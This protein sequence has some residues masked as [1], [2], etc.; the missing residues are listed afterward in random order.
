MKEMNESLSKT[1]SFY[2]DDPKKVEDPKLIED[3][4]KLFAGFI[5]QFEVCYF[6]FYTVRNF[7]D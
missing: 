5:Q 4:L 3:F 7:I 1:L 2:G 6:I